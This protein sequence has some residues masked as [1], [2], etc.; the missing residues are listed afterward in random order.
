M[1]KYVVLFTIMLSVLHVNGNERIGYASLSEECL[2]EG[3]SEHSSLREYV[4]Y[5]LAHNPKVKAYLDR[6]QSALEKI[7]QARS[8]P[9]PN[10]KYVY[11]IEDIQTRTGPQRSQFFIAQ[12][13]PWLGTLRNRGRF[14]EQMAQSGW[15]EYEFQYLDVI[16]K[17]SAAFYEYAYL[18]KAT[19]IA[20]ENISL[21]KK[22]EVIVGEKVKAGGEYQ[23]LLKIQV[24]LEKVRDSLNTLSRAR[25]RQNAKLSAVLN[26]KDVELLPWPDLSAPT[27][28]MD[29][30]GIGLREALKEGNPSIKMLERHSEAQDYKLKL[31]KLKQLPDVT[32]GFN[33]F[34][35]GRAIAPNTQGSGKDPY[36]VTFSVNLPIWFSKNI[37]LRQEA[38][39]DKRA[40]DH[41]LCDKINE[42]EAKLI[43]SVEE[44]HESVERVALYE[45]SLLPKARHSLAI[46]EDSYVAGHSDILNLIDSQRVLLEIELVYWRAI[47]DARKSEITIQALV[48]AIDL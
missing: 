41:M 43:S 20:N 12:T 42:L 16:E 37:A 39:A 15:A 45:Q 30:G 4:E 18:Y 13:F 47:A 17:I 9:D 31:A 35:T 3:F 7:P 32:V 21:L 8:L 24:E 48:G 36:G 10:F 1:M 44:Y 2:Q 23:Q 26:R 34:E 11:L 5:G 14:A 38:R 25:Y 27:D 19:R 29:I 40:A 46:V 6:Y 22:L 28:W 33:Y